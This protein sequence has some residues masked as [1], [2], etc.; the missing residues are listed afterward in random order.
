[1]TCEKCG[2]RGEYKIHL[3]N[4]QGNPIDGYQTYPCDCPAGLKKQFPGAVM[5]YG[6]I[7]DSF[8]Y[9]QSCFESR[10]EELGIDDL[11]QMLGTLIFIPK[12]EK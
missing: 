1:M 12:E 4:G 9:I 6:E 5:E 2:D 10:M 7:L 3:T 11:D 8:G